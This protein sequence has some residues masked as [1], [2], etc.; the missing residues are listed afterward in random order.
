MDRLRPE[1]IPASR[2][3]RSEPIHQHRGTTVESPAVPRQRHPAPPHVHE[4]RFGIAIA[5]TAEEVGFQPADIFPKFSAIAVRP[6]KRLI[7][8]HAPQKRDDRKRSRG[9]RQNVGWPFPRG[10]GLVLAQ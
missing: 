10:L 5:L 6:T 1:S 7:G 9:L 4:I 8:F 2:S 3:W